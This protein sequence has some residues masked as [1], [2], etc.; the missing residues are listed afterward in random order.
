MR[1]GNSNINA[2]NLNA[3]LRPRFTS[4]AS[5]YTANSGSSAGSG[6]PSRGAGLMRANTATAAR[7]GASVGDSGGAASPS[8]SKSLSAQIPGRQGAVSKLP[9]KDGIRFNSLQ[10]FDALPAAGGASAGR[11]G[12][13]NG[14]TNGQNGRGHHRERSWGPSGLSLNLNMNLS[15]AGPKSAS[16]LSFPRFLGR[17]SEEAVTDEDEDDESGA[18]AEIEENETEWGLGQH[19]R[20]FEVSAKDASGQFICNLPLPR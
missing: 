11:P 14:F 7:L 16:A 17:G 13:S 19:M 15:G 4:L 20:L 5:A 8:R 12:S 18:A 3:Y 2:L 6:P 1:S 10:S 9:R